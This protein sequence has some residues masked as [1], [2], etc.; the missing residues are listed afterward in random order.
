M[1]GIPNQQTLTQRGGQAVH[2][3]DRSVGVGFLQ[4][5]RG[6]NGALVGSGKAGGERNHQHIFAFLQRRLHGFCP[7]GGVD[8]GGGGIFAGAQAVVNGLDTLVHG[9]AQALIAESHI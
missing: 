3:G 4:L 2:H 8:G 1:A 7:A 6:D 9:I 5:L